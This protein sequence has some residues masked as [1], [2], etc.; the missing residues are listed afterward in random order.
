MTK[1]EFWL[2]KNCNVWDGSLMYKI[3]GRLT[4]KKRLVNLET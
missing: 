4:L 1:I 2:W 3:N